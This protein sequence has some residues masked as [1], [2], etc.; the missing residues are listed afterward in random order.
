MSNIPTHGSSIVLP[1]AEST[2]KLPLQ[3]VENPP[4]GGIILRP[5]IWAPGL[6][7]QC[8]QLAKPDLHRCQQRTAELRPQ[9]V[10]L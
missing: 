2:N 6:V 3:S 1:V 8:A 5:Q 7:L 4:L 10:W 9:P